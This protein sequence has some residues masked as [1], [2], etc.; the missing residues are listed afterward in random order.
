M[1]GDWIKMRASLRNHPKVVRMASALQTDKL[2]IIGG[3]FSAWCLFDEHSDVGQLVGYTPSALDAEVGLPGL[4]EAMSG[5]GWLTTNGNDGLF[6]PEFETHNGQPSKRRAQESLRKREQRS[7]RTVSAS[8]PQSVDETSVGHA[9]Q[10]REEKSNKEERERK[11]SAPPL[12]RP[13]DVTEQTW[14]DWLALRKAKHAPVTATVLKTAR[15][16]AEKAG[17]PLQRFLEVW[18]MRGSQ[19]LQADWLRP[20]ERRSNPADVARM[21]VPGPTGPDPTLEALK[22]HK[23]APMPPEIRERVAAI[24]R[25]SSQQSPENPQP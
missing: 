15:A 12:A 6:L 4:A 19:G 21:T 14:A 9:G 1:A 3:L 10:R 11:R 2:R 13:E 16:E 8:C 18:C 24:T 20:E 25:K 7:V 22:A 23:G 5:V 17:M